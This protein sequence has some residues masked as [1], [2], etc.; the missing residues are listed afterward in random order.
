[1]ALLYQ[2]QGKLALAEALY[3][4]VLPLRTAK[5]GADHP[6]TVASQNA[7]AGAYYWQGNHAVA[8]ALY[9]D[10]LAVRTA[11]L[12]ADHPDTLTS[13][14]DLAG[15][16]WS[17]KKL[18][19][20][21]P[22]LED[23]LK[24]SKANEHPATLG[25]QAD[26]G[27]IYC[28]AGRFADAIPLLE[29]VHRKGRKQPELAWVGKALLTAYVG[30]G[31]TT[32]AVAMATEQ[33][34]AARKQFPT[35]RP[36]LAAALADTGKALLDAK[37]Y[38]DA[39]P[40]YKEVL[41]IRTAKLGADHLDTILSRD[42]LALLYWSM[43]KL[44]QSIP[45]LEE[46]LERRKAELDPDD[47]EMLGRRVTLGASYCDAGRFADG[48]ALIE[49]VRQ[50][51]RED[52]HPAWV[53]SV[54]LTAYVQAG[55]TTDATALV[56]ER[57]RDARGEFPAD[58]PELAAALADNGKVLLDAKT[59]ADAEPLLR[60]VL[61]FREKTPG[62]F[63]ATHH[64]QSLLGAVLLGQEK[65]AAAEPLLLQG[66]AG[67]KQREAT[68]PSE[69]QGYPTEALERLVQLY[70][71]WGKPDE[72][73]KWRRELEARQSPAEKSASP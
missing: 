52:P 55:R 41:A 25:M 58:S 17:T 70:D 65:Y 21:I 63:W 72:A 11:K 33:V 39:E 9:K 44:D 20:A 18:E 68:I 45:L 53:R 69:V 42:S 73:A 26:L 13:Q 43:K 15:V 37:A 40:L 38:A 6:D 66:Y 46:N 36:Q 50:K 48:I 51:G 49:E 34:R 56:T 59:Y 22:L 64:T 5:L 30:A 7:L 57:V 32:E 2:W 47:P 61:S 29:E 67:L 62:T 16:Y 54:L 4:E 27:A 24:R 10:V 1:L 14:Y 31:K 8:E 23:T 60:E 12:G 3:K 28:D 35:D 19:Q 71:A